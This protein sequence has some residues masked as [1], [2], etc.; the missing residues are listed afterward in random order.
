M[1]LLQ[2]SGYI[3][4]QMQAE[5]VIDVNKFLGAFSI[6]TDKGYLSP[7]SW[8]GCEDDEDSA[9]IL[10]VPLSPLSNTPTGTFNMTDYSKCRQAE[11]IRWLNLQEKRASI[12]PRMQPVSAKAY[13][14]LRD[15][16]VFESGPQQRKAK[17][18][19]GKWC[20]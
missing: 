4:R 16:I 14:E 12:I 1:G 18:K 17:N 7:P 2:M 11:A 20:N 13:Q 15:A 5:V 3:T 19:A 8:T 10:P 6:M 9:I